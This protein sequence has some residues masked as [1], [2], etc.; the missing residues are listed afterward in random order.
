MFKA[1]SAVA[2]L[3]A[4]AASSQANAALVDFD[5]TGANTISF[6]VEQSPT[7]DFVTSNF[8]TLQNVS[9]TFNGTTHVVDIPF[10]ATDFLVGGIT[11][12]TDNSIFTGT[13][14]AP[15]FLTGSYSLRGAFVGSPPLNY[16]L[17]I[18]QVD[19]A[20]PEPA[21]WMLLLL[22]FGGAG[23]S[24]RRARKASLI[25]ASEKGALLQAA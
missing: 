23:L 24:I 8:F 17:T 13:P 12:G 18:S 1:L 20:V 6:T 9:Y 4:F 2:A 16:R 22:G 11:F 19:A 10:S 21:T 5:I 3:L 25:A 15:T 14:A 7:P